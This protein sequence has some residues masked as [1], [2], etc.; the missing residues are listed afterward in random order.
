MSPWAVVEQMMDGRACPGELRGGFSRCPLPGAFLG[1]FHSGAEATRTWSCCFIRLLVAS[2]EILGNKIRRESCQVRVSAQAVGAL[3]GGPPNPPEHVALGAS[4]R[5]GWD[6]SRESRGGV[7][8]EALRPS[9]WRGVW[10]GSRVGLG[11]GL[12]QGEAWQL[13]EGACPGEEMPGIDADGRW[14]AVVR[15]R[16]TWTADPA[17][18][19]PAEKQAT[20]CDWSPVA[21]PGALSLQQPPGHA[22]TFANRAPA[23]QPSPRP[24]PASLPRGLESCLQAGLALQGEG[25]GA[26]LTWAWGGVGVQRGKFT[27]WAFVLDTRTPWCGH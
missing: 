27:G 21:S 11:S 22:G 9:C 13:G 12:G 17:Q 4:C 6:R 25:L 23:W 18:E 15:E 5:G 24:R 7:V 19:G 14:R 26:F 10:I 20:H 2:E 16:A 8:L 3:G 1:P